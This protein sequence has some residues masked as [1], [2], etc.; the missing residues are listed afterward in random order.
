LNTAGIKP[1]G[2]MSIKHITW[3][4]L[5]YMHYLP[6]AMYEEKY[7]NDLNPIQGAKEPENDI[8][9]YLQL[10]TEELQTLWKT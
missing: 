5:L 6:L 7:I 4:V 2:N 1:F 8:D 9:I 3:G 10:L